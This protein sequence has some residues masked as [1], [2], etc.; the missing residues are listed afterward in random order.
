MIY[1]HTECIELPI[2]DNG[3]LLCYCPDIPVTFHLDECGDLHRVSLHHHN[4]DR[5]TVVASG[6][7]F[8]TCRELMET[9]GDR[10][11][12]EAGFRGNRYEHSRPIMG[13][14]FNGNKFAA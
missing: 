8:E 5:K 11:R 6:P 3:V 10:I 4:S 7:I 14:G 12:D 2:V 9:D 1:D 13:V